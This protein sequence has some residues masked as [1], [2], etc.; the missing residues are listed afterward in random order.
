MLEL[1]NS[2]VRS[3]LMAREPMSKEAILKG[4]GEVEALLLKERQNDLEEARVFAELSLENP[5]NDKALA[6]S[7]RR[8][9]AI[10][11]RIKAL[12]ARRAA[13][14]AALV[15]AETLEV[16]QAEQAK[17]DALDAASLRRVDVCGAIDGLLSRLAERMQELSTLSTECLAC[18]ESRPYDVPNMFGRDGVQKLIEYRLFGLTGGAWHPRLIGLATVDESKKSKDMKARALEERDRVLAQFPSPQPQPPHTPEPA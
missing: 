9:D 11:V 12:E 16:A 6:R 5:V 14:E 1:V 13:F 17:R 15:R 10:A 8:G 18:F 2:I 3:L 7:S 4:K